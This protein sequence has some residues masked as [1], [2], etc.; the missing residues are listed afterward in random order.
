MTW[1][2]PKCFGDDMPSRRSGHTLCLVGEFVYLFGGNDFRRPPGP[3]AELFKLDISGS[4]FYWTKVENTSNGRWPE[5]RSHHTAIAI[6]PTKMLIFGGFR[7]SSIR[8][9]DLWIYDT[10]S[11]EW[12]QPH[13]AQTETNPD[14]EVVYKRPWHDVPAPRG[15]H[16]CTLVDTQL[17][18]FGG[19]GG[20]GFARRDFNDMS[21]L[22]IET[23]EWQAVEITG[24][25]HPEPRSGHQAVAVLN[26]IYVLGG[27]NSM[28]QFGNTYIF[29][30]DTK[31]W[32]KSETSFGEARWN[33]C[34]IAVKAVPYYKVFL[35]GGNS[36]DLEEGPRGTYLNDMI[37]LE[38]GS[39]QWTNPTT[40]GELPEA[41]GETQMVYDPKKSAIIMFGGWANR[42]FG[43]VYYLK[44]AEVVGPPYSVDTISP[45]WG[46]ITG[47]SKCKIKGI[48]F[49]S[50]GSVATIRFA[51]PKGF[52]ETPGQ[53]LSD[54]EIEF[55]TPDFQKYGPQG[56]EGRVGV[57]G[58]SLTNSVINYGYFAVTSCETSLVFGPG[59]LDKCV[60]KHPITLII[61]AKDAVGLDRV[62][63]MDFFTVKIFSVTPGKDKPVK[64]AIE[65]F[66]LNIVDSEDGT[67][68]VTYAY[69]EGGKYEV[70]VTFDG[71]FAGK[72]GHLRGSPFTVNVE[73]EGDAMDNDLQGQLVMNYIME[74]T[75][76]VKKYS[77]E[78]LSVL[79]KPIPKEDLDP[80]VKVKE[81][82]IDIEEKK[83]GH[84]LATDSNRSALLYFKKQGND[85]GKILDQLENAATLY[86]DVTKQV[87]VTSNQIVP[88]TKV[89]AVTIESEIEQYCKNVAQ[90]LKDSKKKD[91]YMAEQT[92]AEARKRLVKANEECTE[93]K[94]LLSEKKSLCNTFEFPELVKQ[95][96]I[97]IEEMTQDFHE[98]G[99]VWD[100]IDNLQQFIEASKAILWKEMDTNELEDE[101]KAQVKIVKNLHKCV[102]DKAAYKYAD[103]TSK[104]FLNTIPLIALLGSKS[105]RDRHWTAL[106]QATKITFTPPY[107]DPETKLGTV[108]ALNLHEFSGDV[109]DICDQS[110]KELKIETQLTG[111]KERWATIEWLMDPYMDTD[112]PLLKIGE[113][114]FEQLDTDSLMVQGMLASRFVKQFQDD[115]NHWQHHCLIFLM[116]SF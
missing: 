45:N 47:G 61:Q 33:F 73:D 22:D 70:H 63:G 116:Y 53:V 71:T 28:Q 49:S 113:E 52:I 106:M 57:G 109:E 60:A 99:K 11:N 62:C 93:A 87:P 50:S 34:A 92:P 51:C 78:A 100:A 56:V 110:A 98:I 27:W 77:T 23:W 32:T 83:E 5:P 68:V 48:G 38:T 90:N 64:T 91:I 12:S 108:L 59:I 65:D 79:K 19:Y 75:K 29:N 114:D 103:K 43:D 55:S 4:D 67:Y 76:E 80:L 35:F 21:I 102:R 24:E 74:M 40:V 25:V 85:T 9:N 86:A 69:P 84:E 82:L 15:A 54:N 6:S 97:D 17:Y 2:T 8:Y 105:M 31:E 1:S 41:R 81:K 115:A 7:S 104:D 13:P 72:K 14:G 10:T 96:T 112:V 107:E 111:L 58:R 66:G 95:A 3:N 101:A 94:K 44:V 30:I 39:Q 36:G 16:T 20:Q 42:W 18:I 46:P 88:F 26:D 37:V 89:W